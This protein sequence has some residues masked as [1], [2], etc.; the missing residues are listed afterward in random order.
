MIC[1]LALDFICKNVPMSQMTHPHYEI[2]KLDP[3]DVAHMRDLMSVFADAFED[4]D[5]YLSNPPPTDYLESIL[6]NQSFV[7]LVACDGTK[8]VGGLTA[9]ELV[10][11][12]QCR[13]EFYIYD[14]AVSPPYQ[15]KGVAT[16]LIRTLQSI[17]IARSIDTI[18]VQTDREDAHAIAFYQTIA[19]QT[20]VVHFTMKGLVCKW[21]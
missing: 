7:A 1:A 21:P 15:R 3:I 8:I 9:Y 11:Y 13:K 19:T 4:E 10:K 5:N 18:F 6:K 12:E 16:A 14:I 2:K 17:A 20:D